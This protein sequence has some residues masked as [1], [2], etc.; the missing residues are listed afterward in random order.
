MI[1]RS[2]SCCFCE[3]LG[4]RAFSNSSSFCLTFGSSFG[5]CFRLGLGFGRPSGKGP[6]SPRVSKVIRHRA[7]RRGGILTSARFRL[8][9]WVRC[10]FRL[11]SACGGLLKGPG[12]QEQTFLFSG[13]SGPAAPRL[14][15]ITK[16]KNCT[17]QQP[18]TCLR[19]PHLLAQGQASETVAHEWK[20]LSWT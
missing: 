8:W 16:T 9:F 17:D 14:R 6:S 5:F 10:L 3:G 12:A 4:Q 7:C 2:Q 13:Q 15:Q 19:K 1:C 18:P 20:A 11:R